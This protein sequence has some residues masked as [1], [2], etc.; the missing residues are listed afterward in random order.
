[1]TL[2]LRGRSWKYWSSVFQCFVKKKKRHVWI[3][4]QQALI[5]IGDSI[6]HFLFEIEKNKRAVAAP[7]VLLQFWSLN[8][9]PCLFSCLFGGLCFGSLYPLS[10]FCYFFDFLI[11]STPFS[12]FYN[13]FFTVPLSFFLYWNVR[14]NFFAAVRPH[15]PITTL[16]NM[17]DKKPS[18]MWW[19]SRGLALYYRS[20]AYDCRDYSY[21]YWLGFT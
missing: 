17:M 11:K 3:L 19:R 15:A 12:Y 21:S 2:F 4:Y 14:L 18:L 8:R 16:L 6:S 10:L 5:Q 9:H 20:L 1:M 7:C 13:V